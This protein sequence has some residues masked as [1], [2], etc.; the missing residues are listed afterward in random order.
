MPFPPKGCAPPPASSV[1]GFRFGPVNANTAPL[2][3]RAAERLG[4][5]GR[6]FVFYAPLRRCLKSKNQTLRRR[7]NLMQETAK[8]PLFPLGQIVATPGALAALGKARQT[9]LE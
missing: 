7:T 6:A 8:T 2:T 4:R 5:L 3:A 9:P 1:K